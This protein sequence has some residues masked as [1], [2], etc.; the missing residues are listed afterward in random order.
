M[1]TIT[2]SGGSGLVGQRLST[3]LQQKG[4]KVQILSRSRGENNGVKAFGWDINNQTIDDEAITTADHIIHLAGAGIADKR[5]SPE[6]RMELLDSRTQSAKL[7]LDT[8][9]R[10]GHTPKSFIST[11][12]VG[13][14]GDR[15]H[16]IL[17]EYAEPG[18]GFLTDVCV[19]WEDA[20]KPAIAMNI[21]TV[22]FRVGIVLSSKGGAL[23]KMA[24]P[25]NFHLGTYLGDGNQYYPWIHIDDLCRMYIKAIEDKQMQ[26]TYN[27]VGPKAERNKILTAAIAEA[28][29][30]S[31]LAMPTPAFILKA[32]MGDM[33]NMVL[34]SVRASSDKIEDTGFKFDYPKLVDA[35][36]D[37][38]KRKV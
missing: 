17:H 3:L 6:R 30:K 32:A 10:T 36:K 38:Y 1:E 14:Y 24:L 20:V 9:E 27:A 11:S 31:A 37:L 29:G 5:W 23:E 34:D 12:A 25:V 7:L 21:R 28:K 18:K 8:I 22:I 13:F 4:Y 16:E 15:G 19:A 35:L 2:I 26:G 33:A